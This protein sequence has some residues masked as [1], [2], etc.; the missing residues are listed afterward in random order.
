MRGQVI[1]GYQVSTWCDNRTLIGWVGERAT[2]WAT[3]TCRSTQ[4]KIA[5]TDLWPQGMFTFSEM[6]ALVGSESSFGAYVCHRR[7]G[8]SLATSDLVCACAC[9]RASVCVLVCVC[10]CVWGGGVFVYMC[11]CTCVCVCHAACWC[12]RVRGCRF[13]CVCVG[14]HMCVCTGVCTCA[15]RL[16]CMCKYRLR[17]DEKAV[18]LYKRKL[19][20]LFLIWMYLQV[21]TFATSANTTVTLARHALPPWL[22]SIVNVL[23]DLLE[24]AQAA[25]VRA[26]N[27]RHPTVWLKPNFETWRAI[28]KRLFVSESLSKTK[29]FCIFWKSCISLRCLKRWTFNQIL[30]LLRPAGIDPRVGDGFVWNPI[31]M[32][33]EYTFLDRMQRS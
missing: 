32:A 9:A 20:F 22:A 23:Q 19:S 12:T 26:N 15:Y 3:S 16:V 28:F 33:F 17:T 8:G 24:M 7:P 5:S 27:L 21:S 18:K 1:S 13:C 29:C 10:V 30:S 25:T 31:P 11:L 2:P 14:I 4:V 6:L